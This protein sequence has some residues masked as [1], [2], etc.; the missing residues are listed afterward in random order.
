MSGNKVEEGILV[1][2]S[3]DEEEEIS[4]SSLSIPTR[5]GEETSVPAP[6]R[7]ECPHCQKKFPYDSLLDIHIRIHSREKLCA[8]CH[9]GFARDGICKC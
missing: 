4:P 7:F 6:D 2:T 5:N 1:D 8:V 9:K 3:E